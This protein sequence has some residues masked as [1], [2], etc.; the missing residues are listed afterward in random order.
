[1]LPKVIF[2]F[3][4]TPI[5]IPTE[6]FTD[7]KRKIFNFMWKNKKPRIAKTILYNEGTS[8]GI[9]ISDIKLYYRVTVLKTV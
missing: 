4:A 7:L 9:I 6:F 8:G 5:K 2:R 3:N 1:M